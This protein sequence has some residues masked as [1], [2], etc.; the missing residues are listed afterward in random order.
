MRLRLRRS[1]ALCVIL[2]HPIEDGEGE[3]ND[4]SSDADTYV[5]V[6]DAVSA[7]QWV[8][9]GHECVLLK[10]DPPAVHVGAHGREHESVVPD[11]SHCVC[12]VTGVG[13]GETSFDADVLE[14]FHQAAVEEVLHRGD[15]VFEFLDRLTQ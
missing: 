14:L 12:H 3:V 6:G 9:A 4:F 5:L 11:E 13:L 8:A 15:G 7:M 2:D 1:D 10:R